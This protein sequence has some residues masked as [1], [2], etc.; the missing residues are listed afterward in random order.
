M[1]KNTPPSKAL[2]LITKSV[3][4]I[5]LATFDPL[6]G[7]ALRFTVTLLSLVNPVTVHDPLNV[8]TLLL[9]TMMPLPTCSPCG[10]A[11]AKVACV[12]EKVMLLTLGL[13]A[14]ADPVYSAPWYTVEA[15]GLNM[16]PVKAYLVVATKPLPYWLV[17]SM[18]KLPLA[19]AKLVSLTNMG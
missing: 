3:R 2:W 10:C 4:G 5:T 12:P 16:L 9:L 7:V 13:S 19:P 18:M 11:N 14:Y 6:A 15:L 8:A 1:V 17:F